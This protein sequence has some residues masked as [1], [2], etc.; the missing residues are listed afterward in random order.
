MNPIP[1]FKPEASAEVDEAFLWYESQ[2]PGLG[3]EFMRSLEACLSN[4]QRFP[5]A[6]PEVHEG[7]RR[8]LMRRFPYGIYYLAS[9][10]KM[11]VYAVFH[12]SR[13][14]ANLTDRF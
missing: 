7:I 1:G 10:G 11:T 13:D 4:I 6:A 9:E 5:S 12:F 3:T 8:A 2:S 14:P